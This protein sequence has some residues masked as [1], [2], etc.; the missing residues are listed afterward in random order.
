[1]YSNN[2]KI[3]NHFHESN[4]L[5]FEKRTII[6]LSEVDMIGIDGGTSPAIG[7]VIR[8]SSSHCARLAAVGA[9]AAYEYF[10]GE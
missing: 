9:G 1:M 4:T 2:F 10:F 8:A 7:A 6:S 5:L 3:N